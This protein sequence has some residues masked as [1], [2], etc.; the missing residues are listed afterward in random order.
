MDR[1]SNRRD[2]SNSG[3]LLADNLK[4]NAFILEKIRL[5]VILK[6]YLFLLDII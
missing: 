3:F 2:D 5:E 4:F 6:P 1:K